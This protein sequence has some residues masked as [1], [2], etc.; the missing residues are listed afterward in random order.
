VVHLNFSSVQSL[1]RL[2]GEKYNL[3]K[4]KKMTTFSNHYTHS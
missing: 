4:H 2:G 1:S 3:M